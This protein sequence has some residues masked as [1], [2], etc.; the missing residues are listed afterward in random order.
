MTN[1]IPVPV[2]S[3]SPLTL[4]SSQVLVLS[5]DYLSSYSSSAYLVQRK[6]RKNERLVVKMAPPHKPLVDEYNHKKHVQVSEQ[7]LNQACASHLQA[8]TQGILQGQG[9]DKGR[10]YYKQGTIH[11]RSIQATRVD[12]PGSHKLQGELV[13]AFEYLKY[14]CFLTVQELLWLIAQAVYCIHSAK[15]SA[16][17]SKDACRVNETRL[18]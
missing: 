9:C 13:V 1:I 8:S 7:G 10:T 3:K 11:C 2:Q 12:G 14:N 18:D 16:W 5:C 15:I 17:K 4:P 6:R